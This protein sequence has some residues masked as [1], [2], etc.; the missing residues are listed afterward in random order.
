MKTDM[1]MISTNRIRNLVA[2]VAVVL[3]ATSCSNES[4]R[5]LDRMI[6]EQ[7]AACPIEI[8]GEIAVE[9]V[10]RSGD[11]VVYDVK[12]DDRLSVRQLSENAAVA[13]GLVADAIAGSD[14]PEVRAELETCRD[15]GAKM[16]YMLTDER[17]DTFSIIIDPA[18]YLK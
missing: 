12:V 9:K 11:T 13:R 10:I 6:E 14:S 5:K 8:S 17:G 1:V 15:A 16:K 2:V 4:Q 7:N 3:M 18:E